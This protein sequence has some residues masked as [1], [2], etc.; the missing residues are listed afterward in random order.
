LASQKMMPLPFTLGMEALWQL[1][2]ETDAVLIYLH[3][4]DMTSPHW[5]ALQQFIRRATVPIF[6]AG[7]FDK[8]MLAFLRNL[9]AVPL[10]EDA[11]KSAILIAD[12]LSTEKNQT[13]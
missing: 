12:I 7:I 9:G 2:P 4:M 13:D 6:V 1:S 3:E 10:H 11:R 5:E 8:E